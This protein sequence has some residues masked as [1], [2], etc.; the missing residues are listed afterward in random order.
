MAIMAILDMV[1]RMVRKRAG[2]AQ[3]PKGDPV[4][5]ADVLKYLTGEEPG[6]APEMPGASV[7]VR[8]ERDPGA[9]AVLQR[10]GA[11]APPVAERLRADEKPAAAAPPVPAGEPPA[12]EPRDRTPREIRI[13]S[14]DPRPLAPPPERSPV[15]TSS[16]MSPPAVPSS[17]PEADPV[18]A[19]PARLETR[20]VAPAPVPVRRRPTD[21]LAGQLGLGGSGALRRAVVAREV[22]GPPLALRED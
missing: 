18:G 15:P 11:A 5:G 13:R 7:S 16:A 22:L 3:Q 20:A 21:G 14:R 4:D 19:A 12:P 9:R 1:G 2:G 6:E 10:P 8:P 17:P